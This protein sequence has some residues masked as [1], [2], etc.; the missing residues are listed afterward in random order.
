M[1]MASADELCAGRVVV[2]HG[3][4][5]SEAYVPFCSHALLEAISGQRTEVVDPAMDMVAAQQPGPE[6]VALQKS[7]LAEQAQALKL[8]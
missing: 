2:A 6:F 4:G 5:Y 8:M 7:L 1:M 3:G